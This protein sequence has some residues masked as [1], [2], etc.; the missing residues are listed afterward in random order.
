MAGNDADDD[1]DA[2]NDAPGSL[3]LDK[4]LWYSRIIKSRTLA[5]R[6]IADGKARLNRERVDKPSHSV[7]VDDVVTMAVG[8]RI[9]V[10]RIKALGIR[11]GPPAEAQ[12]LYED[13]TSPSAPLPPHARSSSG[14]RDPGAGRPT[15]RERR[16]IERLKSS[17]E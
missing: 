4:W 15:K 14:E 7:K 11:R 13:L 8:G 6:L 10:L 9:R 5:A 17:D 3:R 12:A 16:Q 1:E 2:S